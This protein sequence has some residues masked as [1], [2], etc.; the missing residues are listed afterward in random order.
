MFQK[1]VDACEQMKT[2]EE[3]IKYVTIDPTKKEIIMW[4]ARI[5]FLFWQKELTLDFCLH[6]FCFLPKGNDDDCMWPVCYN[7]AL[8]GTKSGRSSFVFFS[9]SLPGTV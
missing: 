8:G 5:L 1:I 9:V 2:E 7:Q 6:N 3:A 4:V